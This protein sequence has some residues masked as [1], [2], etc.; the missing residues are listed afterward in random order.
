MPENLQSFAA[1]SSFVVENSTVQPNALEL[2]SRDHTPEE[3][4]E[5]PPP[6]F[7]VYNSKVQ[8]AFPFCQRRS[9]SLGLSCAQ[10][11]KSMQRKYEHSS[12]SVFAVIWIPK[13]AFRAQLMTSD[14][15]T[16]NG[17]TA[18]LKLLS[19]KFVCVWK[20]S[21]VTHMK[22]HRITLESFHAVNSILQEQSVSGR[23]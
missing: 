8:V 14:K 21:A 15:R 4:A 22:T 7:T 1:A 18:T 16:K 2:L 9:V 17:N 5:S 10:D 6:S 13:E 23:E 12:P 11:G 19:G 20:N 3:H